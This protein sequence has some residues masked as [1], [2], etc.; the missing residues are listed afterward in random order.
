MHKDNFFDFDD[1]KITTHEIK[2]NEGKDILEIREDKFPLMLR[3]SRLRPKQLYYR[4]TL[5][6]AGYI[7]VGMVGTRRPSSSARELCRR[8]VRSL[9]G[10]KAVVVSGLAQGIDSYCHEAA[11]DA[12][13]PTV[14]VIAQGLEAPLSGD[15][16]VLAQ[17]IID[18]G[19][20]IV[21]EYPGDAPSY[22]GT[23]PARNRIISGMSRAIVLV[24]SKTKGG[25]L[26]TADYC[27][28]E[29]KLLLAVPGDFD[30]EVSSGP[31]LY[32]DQGKARSVFR[33][34]SLPLVAGIS[35]DLS[36]DG[37]SPA[38]ATISLSGL[39]QVGC[40]LSQDATELFKRFKGFR[41]T[42]S[43]IQDECNFKTGNIL[44]ILT[45]LEI[46]GLVETRDNFQFYFSGSN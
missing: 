38:G 31:N 20:T 24:Q 9:Q 13:I 37:K 23:F 10:T 39:T 28:Q 42:F 8:L 15:R 21:T 18:A 27:L 45:E 40:Q 25:A 4:G 11:L 33:P 16:K 19:G 3:E 41:K 22:R 7:G 26:I 6:P 34:E 12:G 36:L 1:A 35:K 2:R 32:L 30:S 43:E 5:P 17:R 29:G 14:A 44:A 46:A